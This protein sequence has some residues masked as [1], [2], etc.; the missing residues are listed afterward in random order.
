[1]K[2]SIQDAINNQIQIEFYSA[3]L[4]LSMSAHFEDANLKGFAHWTRLQWEEETAHALKF[5]NF[6]QRR[7]GQVE[8]KAI[9]KPSFKVG[10]PLKVFEQILEH[11]QYITERI[12][13][14]YKLAVDE[15]DFAFQTLLNWFV[16]EQVEE[17]ENSRDIIDQL[18]LIGDSGQALYHLDRELASR[19]PEAE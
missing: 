1:M 18:K 7:G 13:K 14:L 4:Y 6:V 3:Y 15:N 10:K 11:E 9:E 19:S 2:A 17:E 8:L 12:N 5:Y 16:D